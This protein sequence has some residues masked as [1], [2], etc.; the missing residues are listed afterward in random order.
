MTQLVSSCHDWATTIH[1]QGQVDEVF[2]DLSKA[3]DK[4]PLC[5]LSVKLPYY[6]FNGSTLAW[7]N[8]FLRNR[9]QAVSVNGSH[10]TRGNVTSGVHQGSVLGPALFLIYINDIKEKI[11]S[12]MRLYADDT[13]MYREINSINDYNILQEHFDT[14]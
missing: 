14:V 1:S 12:N 10:S 5:R 9:V 3:F 7:I 6:G 4:V 8:D 2:L 13:I 11:Q